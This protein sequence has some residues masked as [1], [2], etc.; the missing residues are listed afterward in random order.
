M[1]STEKIDL[2]VVKLLTIQKWNFPKN[3]FFFMASKKKKT[4]TGEMD[5]LDM[6]N[7]CI[8][9]V[10]P[11]FGLV[12]NGNSVWVDKLCITFPHFVSNY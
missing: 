7:C 9:I 2:P 5:N 3:V 4:T 6:F 10:T 12:G 1:L 11:E 8:D